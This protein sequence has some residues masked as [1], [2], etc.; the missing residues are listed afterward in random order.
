MFSIRLR[1]VCI[2]IA[3][4]LND[5]CGSCR[6]SSSTEQVQGVDRVT[7]GMNQLSEVT[8]R[9]AASA[10]ELSSTADSLRDNAQNLWKA[11][12]YFKV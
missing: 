2:I 10:E 12:E 7:G 4:F 1:G 9:N 11:V 3:M 8:Q 6:P 5:E